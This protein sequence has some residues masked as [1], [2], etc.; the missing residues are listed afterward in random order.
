MV[1][2]PARSRRVCP[3]VRGLTEHYRAEM[4]VPRVAATV[5]DRASA[6]MGVL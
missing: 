5:D 4:V 6:L 3:L 1:V 2:H